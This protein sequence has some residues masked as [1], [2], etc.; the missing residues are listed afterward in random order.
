MAT[1]RDYYEGEQVPDPRPSHTRR[2][3]TYLED[4]VLDYP[5]PRHDHPSPADGVQGISLA[6][7]DPYRGYTTPAH[8]DRD[9]ESC[10]TWRSGGKS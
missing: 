7:Q 4:Y 8:R 9:L 1:S 10:I 6:S 3:P 2:V 5:P